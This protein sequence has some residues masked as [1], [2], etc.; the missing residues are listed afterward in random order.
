MAEMFENMKVVVKFKGSDV[1]KRVNFN[2][3]CE[4][5]GIKYQTHQFVLQIII[6]LSA[7]VGTILIEQKLRTLKGFRNHVKSRNQYIFNRDNISYSF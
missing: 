3:G 2:N 7:V 4:L 1:T 6:V 5:V